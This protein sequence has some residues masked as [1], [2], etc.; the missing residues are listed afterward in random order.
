M[1]N[2]IRV[3]L[4]DDH[5]VVRYC[6]GRF[7]DSDA[8]FTVIGH[9]GN[10][11][12]CLDQLHELEPDVVLLDLN[13]PELDGITLCARIT[14]ERP[15]TRV[16]VMTMDDDIE[17]MQRA[18]QAG[19]SGYLLK[20]GAYTE[21]PKALASVNTGMRY[22]TPSMRRALARESIAAR[23]RQHPVD[24]L[25]SREFELL[26]LLASGFSAKECARRMEISQSTISTFRARILDKL[27]LRST[28][29]LI[30][31]AVEHGIGE[32]T[33]PAQATPLPA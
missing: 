14:G 25:S 26:C 32:S 4:V 8:Q 22:I 31:F 29:A 28:A 9:A 23:R 2:P 1:Q 5:A 7:I 21:L 20:R 13:M 24:G 10:G 12:Q 27:G 17:R 16:L 3:M 15:D 11:R 6:V 33:I 30:R 18:F 19:A